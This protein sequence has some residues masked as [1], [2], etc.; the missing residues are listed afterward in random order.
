MV[1]SMTGFGQGTCLRENI[2]CKVEIKAVN[3]RYLDVSIKLP[4][5]ISFVENDIRSLI[6]KRISRGKV[7][8]FVTFEHSSDDEFEVNVNKGLAHAY[9]SALKDLA[10]DYSLR[11]VSVDTVA[12]L[13]NLITI[14]KKNLDEELVRDVVL[15]ASDN[16]LDVLVEMRQ[17]EGLNLKLDIL[18]KLQTIEDLVCDI[19]E[20]SK[21]IV[22]E[23]KQRLEQRIK[24]LTDNVKVDPARIETEVAIFAD[25]CSIDEEI[26]RLKSHI[27]QFRQILQNDEPIGRKLDFLI[28]EMNR[29]TNTT[30]SKANNLRITQVVVDIKSELEKIREQVQNIE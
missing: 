19:I 8:V 12:N 1:K 18:S 22:L 17:K 9:I 7:D 24:D 26:V 3:N 11:D 20:N 30:G 27:E 4:K 2:E 23:Y 21:D 29:E 14:N 10:K 6:A 13:Q 15:N 5:I 28:Q 25:R 16:A